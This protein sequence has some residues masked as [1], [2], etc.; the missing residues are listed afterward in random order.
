MSSIS[1]NSFEY[2]SALAVE[3]RRLFLLLFTML[4][5]LGSSSFLSRMELFW[6]L[7]VF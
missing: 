2:L 7:K 6:W 5:C 1:F 4:I 3:G